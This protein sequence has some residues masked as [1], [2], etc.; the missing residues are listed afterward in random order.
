MNE[1]V[2]AEWINEDLIEEA[3]VDLIKSLNLHGYKYL[4]I[5]FIPNVLSDTC[6]IEVKELLDGFE[7]IDEIA[8]VIVTC[9]S[10]EEKD[11]KWEKELAEER[12][13]RL[14]REANPSFLTLMWRWIVAFKEK[15]CPLITWDYTKDN[16]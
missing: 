12:A 16:K 11:A 13:K 5:H 9:N 8:L 14:K 7:M 2:L 3:V 1:K 6:S 10:E 4:N 15:N